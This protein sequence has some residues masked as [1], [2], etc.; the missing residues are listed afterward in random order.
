[1]TSSNPICL[2][3]SSFP[4]TLYMGGCVYVKLPQSRLILC[5]P[6]GCSPSLAHVNGIFPGKNTGVDCHALLHGIFLTQGWNLL[7]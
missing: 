7:L 6:V 4:N 5:D 3:K 1:M 2:P